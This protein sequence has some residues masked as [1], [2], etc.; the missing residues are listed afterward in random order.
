MKERKNYKLVIFD[1]DGTLIDGT[2]SV[3]R[4]L[5]R[6][7]GIDNHPERIALR[8][9]FHSGKISYKY[10]AKADIELMKRHGANKRKMIKAI[11][12]L[13]LMKGANDVLKILKEKGYKLAIISGGLRFALEKIL[14]SYK[15]IF[16]YVYLSDVMFYK[17]G[18]IK[19]V[20]S[21]ERLK[22]KVKVLKEICKKEKIS[23]KE[24][25]FVGDHDNDVEIAKISGLSIAF[26][27]KSVK[28]NKI[29]DVVINKRDLRRILKYL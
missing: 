12:S 11:S 19:G 29:A 8:E 5:H 10:W 4:T 1:L 28:L 25:V 6:F 22:D 13:K 3:W 18:R 14:P 16:D 27:S 20:K 2:D 23:E 24:C 17:D 7:F 9:K 26:N 15:K 21:D